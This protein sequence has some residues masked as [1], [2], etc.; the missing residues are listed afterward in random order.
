MNNLFL[1]YFVNF[2]MFRAFLGPLSGGRTLWIQQLLVIILF[3]WLP[4]VHI[5]LYS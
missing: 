5:W 4:V 3:R 1:V 2:Y